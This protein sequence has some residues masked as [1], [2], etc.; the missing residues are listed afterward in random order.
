MLSCMALTASNT[1]Y[2][3]LSNATIRQRLTGQLGDVSVVVV[4]VVVIRWLQ[5]RFDFDST[6]V[7][8]PLD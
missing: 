7:R 1:L 3:I 4:V 8:R 2:T 6:A 5:L